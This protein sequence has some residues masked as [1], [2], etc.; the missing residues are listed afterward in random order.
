MWLP[1][2]WNSAAA[3]SDADTTT[4]DQVVRRIRFVGNH[5]VSDNTL[6]TL[7]RTHTN[8]EFLGIPRFTPWYFIWRLT[9]KFGEPP[10][11][12]DTSTVATDIERIKTYYQSIGFLDAGVDTTI[13]E[14]RTNRVE[15]SF[16]ID[17]GRQSVL[18]TLT[19][20]GMPAF[21][22]RNLLQNFYA[23]SR[24]TREQIN[25]STYA[26]NRDFT[27]QAL[28]DERNRI[29]NFLK[30]HGYAAVQRDSV[31]ALV[32]KDSTEQ[33]QLDV[34]FR[35]KPGHIYHFG[36]MQI[37]LAGPEGTGEYPQTDTL[38]GKPFTENNRKIYLKKQPSAQ[39]KFSLLTD[40]LLFKPGQVYNNTL[41]LRTVN[42][43]QNLGML[44]IRKFGLS[45]S[46]GLPDY[47]Q[48]N[49]P[50]VFELQTRPRHQLSTEFFGMERYG[51]GAGMGVTY[52]NNNLFGKAENLQLGLNGNFEY[53]SSSTLNEINYSDST[54]VGASVFQ[55]YEARIDYSV[56]R[57]NFPFAFLDKNL[58]FTNARTRYSLMYTQSN[59][60][61][62]NINADIRFNLRYEV[63]HNDQFS[64]Y[65]DLVEL[66]WLDT[67]P[68][69]EF[70]RSLEEQFGKDSFELKRIKEDFR[71]Q[72]SSVIRYTL[73]DNDTDIIKRDHGHYA[74]YTI[75]AGGNIPYLVDRFFVT[76]DTLEGNLPSLFY[77]SGNSLSY[78]RFFKL[79][80]D[81][82]KYIPIGNEAIF[83]YRVFGGFEHPYGQNKSIPLN[84]R[85]FAGG[86]NDIRGW[87]PYRLGPGGIPP[88]K[89]SI[90]GGE[91]KLAAFTEVRQT[92]LHNVLSADWIAAWFNDAGNVWYGPA[93]NFRGQDSQ[94]LLDEGK[95]YFDRFYK[96]VAVSTGLGLRLDWDYVVARFDFAFRAHDLQAGW[97]NNKQLY[98]SFGIGH[99]F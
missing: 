13:V 38:T 20:E 61:N 91:I 60:L 82:R 50:V 92:F 80:A 28:T 90:N 3:Q 16:I 99:S 30:D 62:F 45:E 96:Q 37:S 57:L 76:P 84:Q 67:T 49:L 71:P 4:T 31:M 35:V 25:D 6:E 41:Y 22:E 33:H 81:Y 93:N 53:V 44:N 15:V 77:I 51:F 69:P 74:E 29:I 98:F 54:S 23:D 56:P 39:T 66:D 18:R 86:S 2:L 87:A 27:Y 17:E 19:Y 85:F 12:L 43:F 14:F 24:L 70:N 64:S 48:E 55:S 79:S 73:R 94:Q 8:R 11:L 7:I 5:N 72:F 95:F 1:A 89:V 65:L 52:T 63:T 36:D 10:A 75:S 40:Q 88:N 32:K 26:V 78:S 83:A 9:H 68:T 34:L 59:Q 47:S 21:D 58:L 97:F 46:G 42:E